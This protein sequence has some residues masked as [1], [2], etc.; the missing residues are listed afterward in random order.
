MA[1]K[2]K[3]SNI[4]KSA[5]KAVK[6]VK[7]AVPKKAAKKT[8]KAA[9]KK[10]VVAKVPAGTRKIQMGEDRIPKAWYNIMADLPVPLQPPLRPRLCS[11]WK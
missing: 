2:A 5:K 11:R 10:I 8:A 3:K 1:K 6:A 9:P 4:K 7:R